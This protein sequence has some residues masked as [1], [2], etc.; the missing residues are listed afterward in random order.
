MCTHLLT[1]LQKCI[2]EKLTDLKGETD[3]SSI[4]VGDFNVPLS[5]KLGTVSSFPRN[6]VS[7][8]LPD[9]QLWIRQLTTA[10]HIL[11]KYKRDI[12][13]GDHVPGHKTKW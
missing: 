1:E 12:H 11:A 5:V 3:K 2:K 8:N 4:S 13:Q 9:L 7:A 10:E 6:T